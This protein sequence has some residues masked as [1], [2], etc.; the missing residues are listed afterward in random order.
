M[1]VLKNVL[2]CVAFGLLLAPVT[3]QAGPLT[4][5]NVNSPAVNCVFNP[6][7]TVVVTDSLGTFIPPGDS[8]TGRL[9]SR[10]YV[11]APGAPAAGLTAYVYRVDMTSATAPKPN[12]VNCVKQLI[13]DIGPVARLP[14]L[15]AA[16]THGP[17]SADV[18]VITSGGLGTIGLSSAVQAGNMVTFT[19]TKP[20]CPK[21]LIVTAAI[22]GETSFFFGLAAKTAPKPSIAKLVYSLGGS[23]TTAA[24]VPIH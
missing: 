4:I 19:F 20:V 6:A 13:L 22:P 7:C 12:A 9:Q 5:V 16:A 10:T 1:S 17:I 2:G 23:A 11:G 8:G 18:F 24:R 3:A 21:P 14:Y 15:T